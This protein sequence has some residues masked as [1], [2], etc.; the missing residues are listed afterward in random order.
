MQRRH[1]LQTT[2]ALSAAPYIHSACAASW[3]NQPVRIIVPYVAGG[4]TDIAARVLA[5][6]LTRNTGQ[7]VVVE[8]R[9]GANTRIGSDLVAKA[10]ADGSVL[11]LTA[12]PF[13]INPSLYNNIPYSVA[14]FAPISMVVRNSLI[15]GATNAFPAVNFK[16][17]LA[18]GKKDAKLMSFASAGNGSMSHMSVELMAAE[19]GLSLTH[20]PYRGSG[21]ALTD[22]VGGQVQLMFDNPSSMLPFITG[23]RVKALAYTGRNRS[24]ALPNTPTL[25]ESGLSNFETVNWFGLFAPAKTPA[26]L[27]DMLNQEVARVLNSPDVTARFAKE[28]VQT[29]ATGRD[30]FAAFL[31]A[32]QVK[33]RRVIKERNIQ[34]D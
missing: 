25:N 9:A 8:N 12:A 32:D 29:A 5:E 1:L 6:G 20:V 7:T 16:E 21:A 11:L 30:N 22:L 26:A 23:N 4:T 18:V 2:A 17:M 27:Q 13:T 15:L 10:A 34:P 19:T 14:D 28:G 24:S 33:W 3:S 31:V